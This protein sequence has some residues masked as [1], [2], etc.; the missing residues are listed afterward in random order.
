VTRSREQLFDRVVLVAAGIAILLVVGGLIWYGV[1]AGRGPAD[2]EPSV[3]D[4][5]RREGDE[6]V[7]KVTIE[8]KG[9]TTAEDLV[10]E[11]TL[12]DESRDVQVPFVT[13][14]DREEVLVSLPG[15]GRPEVRVVSYTEH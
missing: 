9:G 10:V 1:T 8:N 2:L 7:Y 15:S 11:V 3:T 13:K 4:T 14:G 6:R 12:G 5:G